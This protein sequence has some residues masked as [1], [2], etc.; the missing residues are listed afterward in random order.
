ML[1]DVQHVCKDVQHMCV[2]VR[3][4]L[5]QSPEL[6][7]GLSFANIDIDRW[8]NIKNESRLDDLAFA[9]F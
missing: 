8:L 6:E 4:K 3:I 2:I 9:K 1:R 7:L 5:T